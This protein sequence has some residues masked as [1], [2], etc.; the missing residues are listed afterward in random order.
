MYRFVAVGCLYLISGMAGCGRLQARPATPTKEVQR[1]SRP[2]LSSDYPASWAYKQD[3]NVH[4]TKGG[5]IIYI[6]TD[7]CEHRVTPLAVKRR[8]PL[9]LPTVSWCN[10]APLP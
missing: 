10:G 3:L 9:C 8:W 2:A 7:R 6:S 1:Y 4:G 5:G